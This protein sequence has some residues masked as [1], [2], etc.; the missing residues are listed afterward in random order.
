MASDGN[1]PISSNDDI[2]QS[3]VLQPSAEHIARETGELNP[4]NQQESDSKIIKQKN[5]S[6][7]GQTAR[8]TTGLELIKTSDSIKFQLIPI[9]FTPGKSAVGEVAERT[10]KETQKIRMGRKAAG[11]NKRETELDIWYSSKVVSR[12]HCEMW[13]KDGVV[14]IINMSLTYKIAVFKGCWKLIWDF[15]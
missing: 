7:D 11:E 2:R 3:P 15:S 10:I 1:S 13:L 5:I 6:L 4:D 12:A 8:K 9:S 14:T